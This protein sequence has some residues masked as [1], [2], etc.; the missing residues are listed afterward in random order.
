MA[1]TSDESSAPKAP[2]QETSAKKAPKK[3]GKGKRKKKAA[4][5]KTRKPT[6]NYP[7]VALEKAL[8]VAYQIK[9]KNGGNAWSPDQ[10]AAALAMGA[11]GT[12]FYYVTAAARDYGLT[13]GTRETKEIALTDLGREL[14]YAGNP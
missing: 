10:V 2:D 4:G 11:K 5:A 1:D 14:V 13:T 3:E 9:E 6:R 8:Q 7:S 12:D